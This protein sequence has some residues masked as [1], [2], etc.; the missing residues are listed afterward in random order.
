MKSTRM[1]RISKQT[2]SAAILL[3]ALAAPRIAR[4]LYPY[5]W[6]ESEPYLNCGFLISL[7]MKPYIN[8]P[9]CH[10]PGP[11]TILGVLFLILGTSIRTAEV[12]T[13]MLVFA[14]SILV[15]AVGNRINGRVTGIVAAFIYSL[16]YVIFRY[17][18]FE[19]EIYVG[20]PV[21]A[22]VW[23]TMDLAE[24]RNP[25]GKQL[26]I[27]ILLCLA[28]CFKL[29]AVAHTIAILV[30]LVLSGYG[31]RKTVGVALM[32]AGFVA[33]AYFGFYLSYGRNFLIQVFLFQF[34]VH[35]SLSLGPKLRLFREILDINLS[36]GLS[37]L[38]IVFARREIRA[39]L[40]PLCLLLSSFCFVVL[41]NA[42]FWPHNGI[43]LL[44]WLSLFGGYFIASILAWLRGMLFGYNGKSIPAS[45]IVASLL[46]FL[47][48]TM[49][50]FPVKIANWGFGYEKR[51]EIEEVSRF[52]KKNTN[53][54]DKILVP[55]IIAL[56]SNRI[57]VVTFP[58]IAGTMIDLTNR[59]ALNG[60]SAT[61]H[62]SGINQK[63]F[64]LNVESSRRFWLPGLME[65]I[66]N[67]RVPVVIHHSPQNFGPFRPL[68]LK[69]S[70]LQEQGYALAGKSLNYVVWLRR[71]NR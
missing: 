29:T 54:N 42:T 53:P 4:L 23:L 17:H 27:A 25:R 67:G 52:V 11:E 9:L 62:S 6:I 1:T 36:L 5:V 65:A 56:E 55:S 37:A 31:L 3:V 30:F 39:W 45:F 19:R 14:S 43:E 69:D 2:I 21:L 44:P 18:V 68:V 71:P 46:V 26:G 49:F 15:F 38:F 10:P 32:T 57:E 35:A 60:W 33:L 13:Q 20:L 70:F 34:L 12:F 7:G 47:C 41:F 28:F 51:K 61:L 50:V 64:G 66:R 24:N 40:L 48:L 63:D 59:V 22:A 8:F 16:S 58:E